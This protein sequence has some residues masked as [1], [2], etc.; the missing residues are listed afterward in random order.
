MIQISKVSH[1]FI[2]Y[3]PS[4][5]QKGILI[6]F[7]ET[8]VETD[9]YEDLKKEIK[10]NKLEKFYLDAI[11]GTL[12]EFLLFKGGLFEKNDYEKE[13]SN[14][15]DQIGHESI[16][17][18]KTLKINPDKLRPPFCIYVGLPQEFSSTREKIGD[19]FQ[20]FNVCY[21]LLDQKQKFNN[22]GLQQLINH[23]FS[24]LCIKAD[25]DFEKYITKELSKFNITRKVSIIDTNNLVEN[26][27][28]LIE[29]VLKTDYRYYLDLS[30]YEN[31]LKF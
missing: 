19:V 23:Q 26:S 7:E 15:I 13:W 30:N 5:G 8:D 21:A 14:L 25:K 2:P 17:V 22:L 9:L 24:V 12:T 6:E 16:T 3:G 27:D 28:K 20:Y 18:Q 29:K 1:G 10:S 31:F 11:N 4:I